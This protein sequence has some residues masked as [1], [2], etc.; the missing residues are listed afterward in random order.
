[1]HEDDL[2]IDMQD[3]D[4]DETSGDNDSVE[5]SSDMEGCCERSVK[6]DGITAFNDGMSKSHDDNFKAH[7]R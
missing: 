6:D 1:M 5:D 4:E 2:S 3:Y 7:Y